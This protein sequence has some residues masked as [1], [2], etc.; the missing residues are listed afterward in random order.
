M[1]H[2]VTLLVMDQVILYFHA[3]LLFLH[4]YFIAFDKHKVHDDDSLQV[5]LGEASKNV[6]NPSVI[7]QDPR[8]R[9]M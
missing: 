9:F 6:P 1:F 4:L 7:R 8:C 2:F 5:R 3:R